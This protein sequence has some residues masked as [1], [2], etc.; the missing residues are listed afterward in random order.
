[1]PMCRPSR[2][3]SVRR[4]SSAAARQWRRL[5]AAT[6]RNSTR[7][8]SAVRPS[9]ASPRVF[10]T[11]WRRRYDGEFVDEAWIGTGRTDLKAN[12]IRIALRLYRAACGAQLAVLAVLVALSW[13]G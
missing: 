9:R 10:A 1:M 8:A 6:P 12:D 7:R 2:M 11:A 13:L 4:G 5:S 3:H